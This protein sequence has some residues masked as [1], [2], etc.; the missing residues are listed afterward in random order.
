VG[1]PARNQTNVTLS[2]W[3]TFKVQSTDRHKRLN[4]LFIS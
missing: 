1:H 3:K 4:H 2:R